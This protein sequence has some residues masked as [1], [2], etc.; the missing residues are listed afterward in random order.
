MTSNQTTSQFLPTDSAPQFFSRTL[1]ARQ[2]RR[3]I[4]VRSLIVLIASSIIIILYASASSSFPTDAAIRFEPARRLATLVLAI[5]YALNALGWLYWSFRLRL[6]SF[7]SRFSEE[8]FPHSGPHDLDFLYEEY[9][10]EIALLR[11]ERTSANIVNLL[12]AGQMCVVAFSS[13]LY[14]Q[15]L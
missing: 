6:S 9:R 8:H 13:A 15:G 2:E 4:N 10:Q 5:S 1:S 12:A 11:R 14:I 7:D 3:F